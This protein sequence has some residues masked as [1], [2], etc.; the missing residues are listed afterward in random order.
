MNV[1]I[2]LFVLLLTKIHRVVKDKLQIYSTTIYSR[3]D[4]NQIMILK[5]S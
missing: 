3:S 4:V 2:S 1:L 5:N